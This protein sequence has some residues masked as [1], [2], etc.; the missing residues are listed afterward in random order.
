[1]RIG[2]EA[3]WACGSRTGTGNMTLTTVRGLAGL[4][5]PDPL[6]LYLRSCCRTGNPLVGLAGTEARFV[7]ARSTLFRAMIRVGRATRHDRLEVFFS[8]AF[9]LPLGLRVPGVVTVLDLNM[10]RFPGEWLRG[11]RGANLLGLRLTLPF[12]LR[13]ATHVIAISEA[14]RRDLVRYFPSVAGK[15][16][17]IHS[18]FVPRAA[19]AA[20]QAAPAGRDAYF[21]YVGDLIP[22]KNLARILEAFALVKADGRPAL[23]LRLAG[24]DVGGYAAGT[25]QPMARR[26]GLE[27]AVD[28]LGY[29]PQEQL[30][31]LYA[32]ATAM[33]FPSLLEGFGFPILE[34]MAAGVPVITSNVSSCPEVA[35]DAAL[36][37]D[38]Y[39]VPALAGAMQSLLRDPE[40]AATL[41]ERGR[42]QCRQFAPEAAARRHRE[43]FTEIAAAASRRR[44]APP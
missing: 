3:S 14:T 18:G 13:A 22:T 24:R 6:V 10:Y 30:E 33:V 36:C 12:S 31:T 37:I 34:A 28:W 40:L 35:G 44:T 23:R 19:P 4:P 43:L 17:V 32:G 1:M 38:P 27:G 8:P 9:F 16:S 41:K 15:C 21:L 29:V 5:D 20:P 25:L 7:E 2:I 39:S 11:G 42:R 26:L